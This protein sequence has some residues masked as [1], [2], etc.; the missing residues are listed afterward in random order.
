VA[1]GEGVVTFEKGS[2]DNTLRVPIYDKQRGVEEVAICSIDFFLSGFE[3]DK[4]HSINA[5][6]SRSRFDDLR[7]RTEDAVYSQM[8]YTLESERDSA[9]ANNNSKPLHNISTVSVAKGK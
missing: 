2:I 3:V 7:E 9:D 8:S 4:H 6:K 5:D 1:I